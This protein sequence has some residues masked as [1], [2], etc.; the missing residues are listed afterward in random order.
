M[1]HLLSSGKHFDVLLCDVLKQSLRDQCE[2]YIHNLFTVASSL[3]LNYGS[4][5]TKLRKH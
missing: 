4:N 2:V 1:S 5:L 3:F